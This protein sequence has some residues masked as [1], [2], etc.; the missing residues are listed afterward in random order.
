MQTQHFELSNESTDLVRRLIKNRRYQVKIDGMIVVPETDNTEEFEY[1]FD[2]IT[3]NTKFIEVRLF[4]GEKSRNGQAIFLNIPRP[5]QGLSGTDNT[6]APTQ[7]YSHQLELVRKDNEI[8]NLKDKIAELTRQLEA[9][10]AA[11]D[12]KR[13]FEDYKRELEIATLKRELEE[14]R[15]RSNSLAGIAETLAPALLSGIARMPA[16]QK[17]I[18]ALGAISQAMDEPPTQAAV[19]NDDSEIGFATGNNF[20]V[21]DEERQLIEDMRSIFSQKE[22]ELIL[23]YLSA[24]ANNKALL[25]RIMPQQEQPKQQS[26][27]GV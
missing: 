14:T 11:N 2:F 13:T 19:L 12:E 24:A 9:K 22:N 21:S 25:K 26:N 6:H 27:E 5:E 18:P 17:A 1:I 7:S 4:F 15:R 10:K 3:P 23:R 16:A 8:S 20:E